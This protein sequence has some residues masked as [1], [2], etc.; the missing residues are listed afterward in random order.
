MLKL[1]QEFAFKETDFDKNDEL[2]A[3]SLMYI[4]QEAAAEHAGQLNLGFDELIAKN[5][6]WVLTK[7]RFKIHD[8][9]LPNVE[10]R[11]ETYPRPRK[12][13]TFYRDYYVYDSEDN[14]IAAGTS[15]WCIVNFA[16]RKVERARIDF[17]GEFID[18]PAFDDGIAKIKAVDPVFSK[19]YKVGQEDLDQNEHVNNCRYADMIESVI[20]GKGYSEFT[21]HFAKEAV[22]GDE[23]L[24]CR[25]NADDGIFVMGKLED[26]TVIFQSKVTW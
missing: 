9:M 10:Y 3:S 2:K 18:H 23:I 16:T 8:T 4:F 20:E 17:D 26:E 14:L 6:M 22:L 19:S 7:V 25:E 24:L 12:G 1:A 13:I 5:S 11:I 15:H 21:I